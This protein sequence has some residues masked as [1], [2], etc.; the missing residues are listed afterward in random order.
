MNLNKWKKGGSAFSRAFS[1]MRPFLSLKTA[2]KME[3]MN[4]GSTEWAHI[5][6]TELSKDI[7]PT[8][9]GGNNLVELDPWIIYNHDN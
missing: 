4:T 7:V 6:D 1:M 8:Q 9:Y 3:T 2:K 5:I